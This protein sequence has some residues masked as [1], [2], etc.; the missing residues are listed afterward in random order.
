MFSEAWNGALPRSSGNLL[1]FGSASLS[2][3]GGRRSRLGGFRAVEPV[4]DTV[5]GISRKW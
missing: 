2:S 3:H 4:P 5:P 1:L